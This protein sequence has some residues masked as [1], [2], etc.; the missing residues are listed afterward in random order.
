M[1]D[2]QKDTPPEMTPQQWRRLLAIMVTRV[3]LT[4]ALAL[5]AIYFISQ[6]DVKT[7]GT[8]TDGGRVS[9]MV[10]E[11]GFGSIL[12]GGDKS[13]FIATNAEGGRNY[14]G[15][16]FYKKMLNQG[17]TGQSNLP[18][19]SAENKGDFM[20]FTPIWVG[21]DINLLG[22]IKYKPNGVISFK[23][24]PILRDYFT[25]ESGSYIRILDLQKVVISKKDTPS[26]V[27]RK[28]HLLGSRLFKKSSSF[29]SESVLI[30]RGKGIG[31][32]PRIYG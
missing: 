27:E 1:S 12:A 31:L 16:S 29:Y 7:A 23:I 9:Q 20:A 32:Y 11:Y 17:L 25:A 18:I 6:M 2:G 26:K 5:L 4:I 14:D 3:L 21:L 30:L 28:L 22:G 13:Q 10:V 15:E 8:A 19:R 24:Y